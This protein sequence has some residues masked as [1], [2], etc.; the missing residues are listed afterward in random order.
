MRTSKTGR[1]LG[2]PSRTDIT[3]YGNGR[4]RLPCGWPGAEE[5]VVSYSLPDTLTIRAAKRGEIGIRTYGR[6]QTRSPQANLCRV[7]R[8]MGVDPANIAGRYE[9]LETGGD[10]HVRLR[11]AQ[12]S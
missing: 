4:I 5:I 10:L 6:A 2:R 9:P 8:R 1:P 7:F 11:S 12:L 3:I